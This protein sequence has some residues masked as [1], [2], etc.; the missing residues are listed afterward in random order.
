VSGAAP[1]A[2]IPQCRGNGRIGVWSLGLLP[3]CTGNVIV[4]GIYIAPWIACVVAAVAPAYLL[5]RLLEARLF[6]YDPRYFAWTFLPLTILFS[7]GF[8]FVFARP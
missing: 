4:S 6:N 3:G 5:T 1:L 2:A 7:I 8:W